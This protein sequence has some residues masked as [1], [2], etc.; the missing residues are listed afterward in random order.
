MKFSQTEPKLV[1]I[2][3]YSWLSHYHIIV[4]TEVCNLQSLNKLHTTKNNIL[5]ITYI[6]YLYMWV[7]LQTNFHFP[8]KLSTPLLQ[9]QIH[10]HRYR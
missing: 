7:R 8:D 1:V 5:Y 3:S 4:L 6:T 10:H 2:I 9:G